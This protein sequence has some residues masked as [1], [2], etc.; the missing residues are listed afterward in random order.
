MSDKNVEN[1]ITD[2]EMNSEE[3]P[4]WMKLPTV[5]F[6]SLQHK[7][8]GQILVDNQAISE[9]QLQEALKDQEKTTKIK[10]LGEVLVEKEFVTRR[11]A[12]SFSNSTRPS[13]L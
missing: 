4:R 2:K 1:P 12:K 10:K 5:D 9:K 13:I 3:T 6:R 7:T 11:H 8:L